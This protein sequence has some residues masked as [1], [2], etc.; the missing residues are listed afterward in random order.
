[1]RGAAAR[2]ARPR[3]AAM[4]AQVEKQ[5]RLVAIRFSILLLL[6]RRTSCSGQALQRR[7]ANPRNLT[8]YHGE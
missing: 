1:M 7:P 6:H 8:V 2:A 4:V 3:R 5:P